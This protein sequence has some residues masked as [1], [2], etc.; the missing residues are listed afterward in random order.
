MRFSVEHMIQMSET[1]LQAGLIAVSAVAVMVI[2]VVIFIDE[3]RRR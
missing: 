3:V 2:A 1:K